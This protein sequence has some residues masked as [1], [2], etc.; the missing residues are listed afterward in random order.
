MGNLRILLSPRLNREK[1]PLPK[2]AVETAGY[3]RLPL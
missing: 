3:Y 1:E 2:S